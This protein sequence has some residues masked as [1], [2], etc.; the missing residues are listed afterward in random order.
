MLTAA[1][2]ISLNLKVELKTS[3]G[4]VSNIEISILCDGW[5]VKTRNFISCIKSSC[6]KSRELIYAL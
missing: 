6:L 4:E 5:L 1:E 3:S 2:L